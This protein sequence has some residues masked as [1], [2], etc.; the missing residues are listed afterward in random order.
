VKLRAFI[1]T[2]V[3]PGHPSGNG[4]LLTT[5]FEMSGG[6]PAREPIAVLPIW[7]R[8]EAGYGE[9]DRT[10]TE[11][12]GKSAITVPEASAFKVRTYVTGHGQGNAENCAEFCPRE[13][14]VKVGGTR[15]A[16]RI[17]RDDCAT[18]SVPNQG[19]N[20][21]SPRAGWCP[22][23]EVRPWDVDVTAAV[24]SGERIDFSYEVQTYVNSCHPRAPICTGCVFGT[25]C[26]FDTG[27]H[28]PP[29]YS[30]SSVLIAYR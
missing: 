7:T 8:R 3:G 9:P 23:A 22:G 13:H 5:A 27:L 10:V 19:G 14:A 2:W 21:N 18:S 25:P 26:A 1:D 17:W 30:V 16:A 11:S 6:L 28:T 24:Q 20:R 29:Y 12:I 4:W 15:F